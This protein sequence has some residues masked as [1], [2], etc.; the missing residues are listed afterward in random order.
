M[1]F[2]ILRIWGSA[3]ESTISTNS[4]PST[5][6]PFWYGSHCGRNALSE[7]LLTMQIEMLLSH[8]FALVF[9]GIILLASLQGCNTHSICRIHNSFC[10]SVSSIIP[11]CKINWLFWRWKWRISILQNLTQ[12]MKWVAEHLGCLEHTR[13]QYGC[14]VKPHQVNNYPQ[15]MSQQILLHSHPSISSKPASIMS[16]P[17]R[18]K[19]TINCSYLSI[20]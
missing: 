4:V 2:Y 9:A 6:P 8:V 15:W 17:S 14:P 12:L 1:Y 20:S 11:F 16:H 10:C 3:I 13:A 18:Y 19:S 5:L 7:L